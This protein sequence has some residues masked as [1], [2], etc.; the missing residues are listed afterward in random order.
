MRSHKSLTRSLIAAGLLVAAAIFF[1]A[2]GA[3]SQR[4]NG[5]NT[6]PGAGALSNILFGGCLASVLALIVFGVVTLVQSRMS[7][8]SGDQR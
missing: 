3:T 4:A 6:G 2:A 8:S 1:F 5:A 7:H